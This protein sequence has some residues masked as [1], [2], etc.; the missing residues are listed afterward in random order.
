MST[1]FQTSIDDLAGI[2]A[3]SNNLSEWNFRGITISA[4]QYSGDI[5][6]DLAAL[7]AKDISDNTN[8]AT[9]KADHCHKSAEG[10]AR[11]FFFDRRLSASTCAANSYV[12]TEA[13]MRPNYTPPSFESMSQ[14]STY[15][16]TPTTSVDEHGDDSVFPVQNGSVELQ[17]PSLYS[18]FPAYASGP[19]PLESWYNGHERHELIAY[20]LSYP[21]SDSMARRELKKSDG[22]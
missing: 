22:K 11:P 1:S 5:D 13:S 9:V 18:H 15:I 19:T 7:A 16:H 10:P 21:K 14:F 12:A 8:P 20:K 2:T 4:E 17:Q 6:A 3:S